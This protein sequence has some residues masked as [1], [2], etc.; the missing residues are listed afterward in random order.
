MVA[1][2]TVNVRGIFYT[3]LRLYANNVSLHWHTGSSDPPNSVARVP[4]DASNAIDWPSEGFAGVVAVFNGG[5]KVAAKAGGASVD[6]V[7]L[8][9]LVVGDA[10]IA[11]NDRGQ[12]EMGTWGA[13]G[14]PSKNFGTLALRQNLLPLVTSGTIAATALAGWWGKWGDPLKENPS[15]PRSAIGVD[16]Q[17]NLI[18]VAS[19]TG[20]LPAQLG[21]ALRKAGAVYGMEMDMNPN[22]PIMGAATTPLHQAG[23]FSVQ[24][25]NSQH[26]ASIYATGWTRDF[27]VA[28]AEPSTPGCYWAS[29]G[30]THA[31]FVAAVGV[32]Q[33]LALTGDTCSH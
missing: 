22:W 17:G 3:A 25:P 18:Y 11:L 28:V 4:V 27:F 13:P 16:A 9:P 12:W 20:S 10:T 32:P 5:F 24:L 26:D 19:M 14:F 21:E 1:T 30:L 23:T 8:E 33:P 15:E 29:P 31:Q 2:S 6:G 7:R